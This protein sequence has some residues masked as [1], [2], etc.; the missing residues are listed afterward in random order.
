MAVLRAVGVSGP[1]PV[2][3]PDLL[4]SA[5]L[6]VERGGD[7]GVAEVISLEQQIFSG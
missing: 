1:A 5:G 4:A 2:W 6:D 7:A 3:A